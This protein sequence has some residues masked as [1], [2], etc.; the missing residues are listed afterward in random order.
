MSDLKPKVIRN[1]SLEFRQGIRVVWKGSAFG[2]GKDRAVEI[3][4]SENIFNAL[5]WGSV[6]SR[7]Y[8]V[9]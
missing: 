2:P 6:L 7:S 9:S 3:V 1:G 5:E 8:W 4:K